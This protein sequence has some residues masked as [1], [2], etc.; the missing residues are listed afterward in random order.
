MDKDTEIFKGKSFANLA[1]DI[2]STSKKKE[3][4]I[5]LLIAELK[6]L[7]SNIGDATII[8]PLIKDYLEIGVKNDELVVKLSSLI[9]RMIANNGTGND[10]DFGISEEEKKQLLDTLGEIEDLD[11]SV[12][13]A[14][15]KTS[16]SIDGIQTENK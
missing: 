11:K 12:K 2:Y 10:S 1:E 15:V 5:N 9:Q 8:V 7:I 3:T 4:Q 6:P 14:K 13:E 16:E